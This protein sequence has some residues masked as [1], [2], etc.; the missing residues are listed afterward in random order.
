MLVRL[1]EAGRDHGD[2]R[3]GPVEGALRSLTHLME[4]MPAAQD[5]LG[6]SGGLL[7]I[8]GKHSHT[9]MFNFTGVAE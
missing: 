4:D 3:G 2:V 9:T 6:A 7:P 8:V 5:T 1:V